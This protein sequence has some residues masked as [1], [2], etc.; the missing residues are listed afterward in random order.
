MTDW[1]IPFDPLGAFCRE[2]HTALAPT[3]SGSLDGLTFATKD[4]MAIEG[5]ADRPLLVG[6]LRAH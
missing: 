5:G 1:K 4:V 3:G 6:A 2:N